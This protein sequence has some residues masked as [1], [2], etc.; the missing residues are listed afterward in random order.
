MRTFTRVCAIVAGSLMLATPAAAQDRS[1]SRDI[2][3]Q[4]RELARQI[5][6]VVQAATPQIEAAAQALARSV[7]A[8]AR[9][10]EAQGD[11][12]PRPPRP[13][14]PNPNPN[15]NPD[16]NPRRE[17]GP[18]FTENFSKTVKLGRTGSFD[19]SNV[20]GDVTITGGG[21]D[22]VRIDAIKRVHLGN[23]A[24]A[25]ALLRD[26]EI[27][28]TE[29]NGFVEV[30]TDFPRRR[31]FS[32]EVDYTIALPTGANVAVKTVSGDLKV[33]NVKGELRAESVSGDL[34]ASGIGKFRSARSVSGSISITDA[35][36]DD[37]SG[38]S[39]SGDF[40]LR[41][42]KARSVDL[43]TVSGDL[44][45]TDCE[46]DRASLKSVSGDVTY[47]GRLARNGRYELQTHSG[48]IRV[49]PAGN[50]GFDLEASTFS[51]DVHSDYSLTL[52]RSGN[53]FAGRRGPQRSIRASFGDASAILSLRSFSGDIAVAKR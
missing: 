22:D 11:R 50:T 1:I 24:D 2:E 6:A 38:G 8:Q 40:T 29:R 43:E 23:E 15:P 41:N 7:E 27:Q 47:A 42:V 5:E 12:P 19:L 3:A 32:G 35:E 4:A 14:R 37:L 49:T 18:A 36:A 13:A 25:R 17:R 39:V 33:T 9:A 44:G 31:N 20:A 21:G 48:D 30:R 16:P 26:I 46:C 28:V 51:G 34:N 53:A 10:F 52:E 45:L